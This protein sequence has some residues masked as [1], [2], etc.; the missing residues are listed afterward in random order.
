VNE[1]KVAIIVLNWNGW[2]DTINCLKSLRDITYNNYRIILIDNG[3]TDD[4]IKQLLRYTHDN[5]N[6]TFLSKSNNIGFAKGC[7]Y[8]IRYANEHIGADWILLLNNDTTVDPNFLT[9]MM[10]GAARSKDVGMIQPL[11]YRMNDTDII[12]STGHVLRWGLVIDRSNGL[13][14]HREYSEGL[15]GCSGAA[16]L[17][18]IS[19]LN[20]IGLFDETYDS[21]FEDSELSW[22]AYKAGWRT[23]YDPDAIVYH[24]RSTSLNKRISEDPVFALTFYKHSARPCKKHGT[25]I[26]KIQLFISSFYHAGKSEIGMWMGRNKV[27]A[28]PYLLCIR[29]LI[30]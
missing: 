22:R 13:P 1:P 8:G 28:M 5:D 2:Q 26:Q 12:D 11:M 19:M 6:I 10:Y 30:S 20:E 24:K 25:A 29:E 4:S 23:A 9:E 21:G 16:G 7:N 3:S 18:R 15:I 27:G 14:R 17:Y